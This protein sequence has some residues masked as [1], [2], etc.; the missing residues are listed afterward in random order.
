MTNKNLIIGSDLLAN[1]IHSEY[2]I[3][4]VLKRFKIDLGFG[5]HNIS[6]ICRKNKVNED[7]FLE[8]INIYLDQSYFPTKRLKSFSIKL[9]TEF[10]EQSHNY[11]NNEK[12]LSIESKIEKLEW[13]GPDHERNLEVLKKFFNQY[14]NEVKEHT[15]HEERVV[16]PYAEFIEESS[17]SKEIPGDVSERMKKYSITNYAQEHNDIEEKLDDLKN[18]IIK[19]LPAP[20]NQSTLHEILNDLFLLQN[21]LN[22]HGRIEE[23]ILVP[24][25]LDMEE[26]LKLKIK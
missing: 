14:K 11:Y 19:Y 16:Y 6:E 13:N 4:S 1:V 10:L 18:I 23:K 9:I 26:K 5:D 25:I 21:D 8:I 3:L 24:K 7:F 2:R 15:D 17:N 20:K 22:N 12:I